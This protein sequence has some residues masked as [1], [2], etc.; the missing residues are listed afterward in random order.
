MKKTLIATVA[1]L[2]ASL[3][4]GWQP[5]AHAEM[6]L[7]DGKVQVAQTDVQLPKGGMTMAAVEARFGTPRERHP[8][9]GTPPI[10]RWD[11]ERFSVFFEKD[12]V[13]DAV[14]PPEAP[15]SGAVEAGT[16]SASPDSEPAI[17]ASAPAAPGPAA[18]AP[19]PADG[20]AAAP[21]NS[22][23]GSSAPQ[24]APAAP[25]LINIASGAAATATPAAQGAAAPQAA[26]EPA[27]A[28]PASKPAAQ[29]TTPPAVAPAP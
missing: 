5:A 28:Q 23:P 16:P 4:A 9:V 1:A 18:S 13:I 3:L 26:S 10:T 12:R 22:A 2:T 11:Y 29:P 21:A 25:G 27:T 8:T 19:T 15:T 17:P 24:A 20:G 7:V 6:V 14:V